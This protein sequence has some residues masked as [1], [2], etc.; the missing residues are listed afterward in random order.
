MADH[1]RV[2]VTAGPG[3]YLFHRNTGRGDADGVVIRLLVAFNYAKA[4]FSVQITQGPFQNRSFARARRTHEIQDE[5]TFLLEH[6]SVSRRKPVILGEDIGFNADRFRSG[7]VVMVMLVLVL[8]TM[9]MIMSMRVSMPVLMTM[10]VIMF[11]FVITMMMF[12]GTTTASCTHNLFYLQFFN[13]QFLAGKDVNLESAAGGTGF[14]I[15][16]HGEF[17]GAFPA[18]APTRY[19]LDNQPRPIEQRIFRAGLEAEFH[20]FRY[21]IAQ[22]AYLQNDRQHAFA[23]GSAFTY[24]HDTL[25]N[26][27]LVH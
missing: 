10:L 6:G 26:R 15:C 11:M 3:I 7:S 24:F 4:V 14:V 20:R 1:V 16:L 12:F 22:F 17:G 2:E 18:S 27:H 23:G 21:D 9:V 8:V 25:R 19:P 5:N 13:S